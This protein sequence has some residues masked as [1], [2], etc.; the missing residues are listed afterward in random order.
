[1]TS[2]KICKP[3][4]GAIGEEM[5]LLHNILWCDKKEVAFFHN[6]SFLFPLFLG[7]SCA[8]MILTDELCEVEDEYR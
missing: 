3:K 7:E 1:M 4:A 6:F 8:I 2:A 5:I